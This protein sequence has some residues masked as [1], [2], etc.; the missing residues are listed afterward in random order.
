MPHEGRHFSMKISIWQ[1]AA[2][3]GLFLTG[4]MVM[5]AGAEPQQKQR[6]KQQRENVQRAERVQPRERQTAGGLIVDSEER[7]VVVTGSYIPQKVSRRSIGTNSAH[8][9]RIFTQRE[10]Q[11]I[12]GGFGVGGIALDPSVTISGR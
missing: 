10:L 11:T 12:N 5:N 7:Y 8:N 2:L 6:S 3:T 4:A 9:V 1:K